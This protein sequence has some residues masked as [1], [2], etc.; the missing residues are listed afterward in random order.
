M[1]ANAKASTD[2]ESDANFDVEGKGAWDQQ[3]DSRRT[4]GAYG[5][6]GSS[7]TVGQAPVPDEVPLLGA[8]H[9]LLLAE[10]AKASC[11]CLAVVLGQ[12]TLQALIWTG[13]RP[14]TDPNTQLVIALS[15]DG[16]SCPKGGSG[17]SYMGYRKQ[18]GDVIVTVE[19]AVAG[20]PV[21]Q[22]AIIPRPDAGKQVLVEPSGDIPY[23]RGLGGEA[24]CALGQG[25]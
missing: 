22:G 25:H 24:R 5:E 23:G 16:V 12:P 8:R 11:Q 17:G 15:S 9:D 2:G 7:A 21:T 20:R 4:S 14:T 13:R 1:S 3:S 10:G 19:S 6:D 18:D